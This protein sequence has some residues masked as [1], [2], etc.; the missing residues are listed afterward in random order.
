MLALPSKSHPC[1]FCSFRTLIRQKQ[2]LGSRQSR[3]ESRREYSTSPSFFLQTRSSAPRFRRPAKKSTSLRPLLTPDQTAS[4]TL[5]DA[6]PKLKRR[7]ETKKAANDSDLT[8]LTSLDPTGLGW[9]SFAERLKV[10]LKDP[11]DVTSKDSILL[12]KIGRLASGSDWAEDLVYGLH[13]AFIDHVLEHGYHKTD[14]DP[15]RSST[16]DLRFPTEWYSGARQIQREV[17]LHVGPTNS[18]KTYNAL[19]RLEEKGSGFYAGPLR[20]L[21]HEVYSRFKAKGVPCDLVTGDDVRLDD[22]EEVSISA[23]TVEMVDTTRSVEVAVIDEIQMIE[24]GDRGWAWTRAFLG[25]NATEVHLCGENRVIPLIRELTASMGDTLH[26]HEYKRL[27][28]LKV[29]SRSLDG[30]FKKLKKGDCMVSFSIFTLHALKKQIEVDTGRRCAIVYGS[31]PPET[32]AQQAALFNDPDN[33]YDF[34]VASDAIGM[35]L[36]L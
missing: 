13:H 9:T 1:L 12:G 21:A 27:N 5:N 22:N 16:T 11:E 15:G 26:I 8:L 19:K 35:G 30:D 32:R 7:L 29:M 36:N 20:L 3:H 31:L 4:R 18:G 10:I 6:L 28:A 34:L 23:S 25:A 33:E 14:T 2:T 24:S 17:H